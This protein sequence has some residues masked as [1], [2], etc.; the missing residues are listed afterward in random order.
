MV[1]FRSQKL[2]ETC[3]PRSTKPLAR[4]TSLM[5]KVDFEMAINQRRRQ[6]QRWSGEGNQ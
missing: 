1:A 6:R 5:D 2:S 3:L 4:V